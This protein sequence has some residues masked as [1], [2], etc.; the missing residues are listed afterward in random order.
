MARS[1]QLPAPPAV[2]LPA[3]GLP[4][5]GLP[6]PGLPVP[7]PGG[8]AFSLPAC[9]E[10]ETESHLHRSSH[11]GKKK[12]QAEKGIFQDDFVQHLIYAEVT[13]ELNK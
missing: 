13:C 12:K 1:E 6:S 10:E 4:V 8:P 5:P 9:R 2:A 3:P 7:V 11:W